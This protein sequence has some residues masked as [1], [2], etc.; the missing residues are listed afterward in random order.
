M[1]QDESEQIL[2]NH[3]QQTSMLEVQ[4]V[5]R[6]KY[7]AIRELAEQGIAKK[8]IARA[9]GLDIK[10]VRKYLEQEQWVSYRREPATR[11]VLSG[12]EDWI[13]NRASE[14]DYKGK[15]SSLTNGDSPLVPLV[16]FL[17]RW[18]PRCQLSLGHAHK[19]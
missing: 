6:D 14:V 10:T 19:V 13:K 12:F 4:M 16:L 15:G 1:K 18:L 7:G 2:H 9:L 17:G 5:H 11:T 8:A 3:L